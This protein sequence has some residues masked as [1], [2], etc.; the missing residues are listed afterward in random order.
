MSPGRNHRSPLCVKAREVFFISAEH[1][2]ASAWATLRRY[3]LLAL[4]PVLWEWL[5]KV[6][7]VL[8]GYFPVSW[9]ANK[10]FQVKLQLPPALP[11]ADDLV[12][13]TSLTGPGSPPWVLMIV[14]GLASALVQAG[15]LHLLRS[16][17]EGRAP[18]AGAFADGVNRYAG[19]YLLWRLIV[20]SV[21]M[22]AALLATSM[23]V[24][25]VALLLIA[26]VLAIPFYLVDFL[27]VSEDLSLGE[28]LHLAPGRLLE[29]LPALARVA[30]V[31]VIASAALSAL[32]TSTGVRTVWVVSPVWSWVG[33]WLA[34]AV[35]LLLS[36]SHQG[37]ENDAQT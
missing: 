37:T 7:L 26:F 28:A 8:T 12:G 14:A 5:Y 15:Y 10:G 18:S 32:F 20:T 4:A 35:L 19:R 21:L 30:L 24:V 34:L 33:T 25:G 9:A 17:V 27:I 13:Q 6:L 16:A 3:P 23:G 29:N 31:S 36:R 11:S 1:A 2:L 22:V